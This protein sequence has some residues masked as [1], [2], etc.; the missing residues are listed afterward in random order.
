[1]IV[2]EL[3]KTVLRADCKNAAPTQLSGDLSG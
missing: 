2:Y 3:M 1:M